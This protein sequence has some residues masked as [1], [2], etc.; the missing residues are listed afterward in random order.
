S[1]LKLQSR[2]LRYAN[3]VQDLLDDVENSPVVATKRQNV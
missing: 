1:P 3:D 2:K